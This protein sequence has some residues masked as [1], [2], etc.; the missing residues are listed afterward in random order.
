MTAT[1]ARLAV[2]PKLE[3]IATV[4]EA[5]EFRA[6]AASLDEA[7]AG[8]FALACVEAFTNIVRHAGVQPEGGCI[9]ITIDVLADRLQ[10]DFIHSGRYFDPPSTLPEVRFDQYP[11]GGL[12][13]R[14]IREASDEVRYLR[15]EGSNT[16]RLVKHLP[17]RG[18]LPSR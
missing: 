1:S 6:L 3:A 12:G 16:V 18:P 5:V 7:A 17:S 11:E 2:P 8:L 4:R 15:G 9:E 10:V 13:L 14:I